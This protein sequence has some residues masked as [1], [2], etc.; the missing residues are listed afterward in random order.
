[1]RRPGYSL[2]F[3]VVCLLGVVAAPS[4]P[5]LRAQG[6]QPAIL[7]IDG[8]TL[9]DGNGG[10][11]TRDAQVV[12][13]G[14]KI[15]R[16]GRK[17]QA[18]PNGAQV[19]N[20]DGKYI[21][22]GLIDSLTNYLWYQGEIYL[23]SGVTSYVG[24]G[25]MGEVG[26]EYAEGIRRGKI[27][28]PRPI[29]WAVHFVGPAGNLVGLESQFDAPHPLASPA[30]AREW[31]KR[32]LDLGGYG[33]TFQNGA[34][35]PETFQAAVDVAHAAGKPIGIRAGGNI[36]A[37]QASMMGADFIPRS[38]G[39]GAVVT[40]L[41]PARGGGFGGGPGGAN[42]LDQWA[43]I[44]D[45]KATDLIRVLVQQKT[46]LIPAFNQKAPGLPSN[47]ARF[48]LQSRRVFAD[49]ML[50]AYY[51]S[52]RAQA[53]LFNFL[54]P[55]NLQPDV[56]EARRRGFKN[57]LNFHRRLIEAGGRVLV[58]TDGGNFAMPG[59]G[60]LHEMQTF[61]DDMG[62]TPMQAL[63]AA[64][65]WPAETMRLQNQMGTIAVGRF[66]DILM[67]N[68][69]PLAK[70]SNLQDI[71]Y[72]IADGR[73]Q[74][75]GYHASY[76]SPF[77]GEGPITLPVV[78]D[79][80]WAVNVKRQ[81]L[82][83]RGGGGGGAPAVPDDPA[84]AGGRQGGRGGRGRA[85]APDGAAAPGAAPADAA[86]V[87]PALAAPLPAGFGANRQPQPTIETIDPGR[88]D[89]VDPDY[90]KAVVKEG[91]PTLTLKLTGFNYFQ[92]SQVYFNN[93]P[94]PT[95]VISRIA[96]EATVDESLLRTA[97]RY[98][99][100]VK[101]LGLADPANPALGNGT[102]NKAWLIVGYR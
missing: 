102:S 89:Y 29:D 54:D 2:L 101:N 53:I 44:D 9:I 95:K 76:W 8:G 50:M 39:V 79:I 67:V 43:N 4:R 61:V 6:A 91:G 18:R 88:R 46:A 23:N 3:F 80:G 93:I 16:I 25:D 34:A 72:V 37:R 81:A 59:I 56:V 75:R 58:G 51:P 83:G 92:R 33:I 94:V 74:E 28:A 86:A 1:M 41:P 14:N 68:Q 65:K 96:I 71:A 26:V 27:R 98:T 13:E 47:W 82:A 7:V 57:A 30:E 85:G 52:S 70:I 99:V 36:D 12:I 38:N 22:P 55:P 63:Q 69:D 24:I 20:G 35:S 84:A 90:S 87:A 97:G 100:V 77:Q 78:D 5:S 15:T 48:E 31:T 62:L 60:A 73:V 32:L 10:A 66:A 49:P 21:V 19:I 11:P 17:G 64:T 45:A 40:T 42:E